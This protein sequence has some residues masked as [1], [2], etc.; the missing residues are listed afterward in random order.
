MTWIV[1]TGDLGSGKG[2]DFGVVSDGHGFEDSPD[3]ERIAGGINSKGPYAVAIGRQANLLQWGF[4]AAPD[5]M[6]DS[7]RRAFLNAIVY[8]HRFD[9]AKP[10]VTK[11][12]RG[13]SWLDQYVEAL[14]DV[15]APEAEGS[16]RKY[17]LGQFPPEVV[18]RTGG[19]AAKLAEWV[20]EVREY[21]RRNDQ[22]KFVVDEDLKARDLS[23]R[24]PEFLHWLV[25]SL[26]TDP[27]DPLALRLAA[28]YLGEHGKDAATAVA[29]IEANQGR[30][31][32]SDVGG[33]RWFVDTR[34]VVR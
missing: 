23:N 10:L 25:K 34:G 5:R 31:F 21:V 20:D 11:E 28:R 1:Q 13:R 4:Y 8:M 3:C 29:W 17:Y 22:G 19:S 32:F 15:E 27:D 9:G 6:T 33:Y 16:V 30:L 24:K 2:N 26:D 7:A 14:R 12:S 18:A